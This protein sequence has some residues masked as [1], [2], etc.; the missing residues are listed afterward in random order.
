VAFVVKFSPYTEKSAKG[1]LSIFLASAY[2]AAGIKKAE[3][4]TSAFLF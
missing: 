4:F 2:T 3:A 1:A